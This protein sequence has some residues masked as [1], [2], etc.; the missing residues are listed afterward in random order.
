MYIL[1]LVTE[2]PWEWLEE[3]HE[4][5]PRWLEEVLGEGILEDGGYEVVE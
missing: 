4:V 3:I 5:V 2:S 1:T